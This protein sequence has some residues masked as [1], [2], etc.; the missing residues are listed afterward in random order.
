MAPI[1]WNDLFLLLLSVT[2]LW[3]ILFLSKLK[4]FNAD[5]VIKS[6]P[7]YKVHVSNN[8]YKMTKTQQTCRR[9]VQITKS[10]FILKL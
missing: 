10:S 4:C 2:T 6:P 7:L 8:S 9:P 1:Q 5:R 3:Q